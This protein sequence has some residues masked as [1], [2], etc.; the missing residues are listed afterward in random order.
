MMTPPRATPYAPRAHY[1]AKNGYPFPEAMATFM[2]EDEPRE[3]GSDNANPA[4]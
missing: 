3:I 2:P 4:L 1:I